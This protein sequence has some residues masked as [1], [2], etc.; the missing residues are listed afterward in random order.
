M[1]RPDSHELEPLLQRALAGDL[2]AREALLARLRPYFHVLVRK[3]LGIDPGDDMLRSDLVQSSMRRVWE[4]FDDLHEPH[5][6][7]LLGWLGRIV[8]NRCYDERRRQ[9][10]HPVGMLPA[11]VEAQ[12]SERLPWEQV[13]E[14]DR[15]ALWVASALEQLP[16]RKRQ[17]VEMFFLDRLSDAEI[18]QRIGGSQ[19]AIRVL[20]HRAL[21]DLRQLM[22]ADHVDQR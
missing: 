17:V 14:R 3:H 16:L 2:Q 18:C 10:R 11:E 6:P 21:K 15:R 13:L 8:R 7:Q 1:S 4:H 9:Q 22:E 19:K 20:R 12:L 5:V